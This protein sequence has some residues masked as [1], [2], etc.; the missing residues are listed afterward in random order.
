MSETINLCAPS[1]DP[2]DSYGQIACRLAWHLSQ[3][4]GVH[5]N[6]I[7]PGEILHDSQSAA[8]RAIL[9]QPIRPAVGGLVLGYPTTADLFGGMVAAG[10][11]VA[12]TNWE[13]TIPPEGWVAAL[14]G[15]AAVSVASTF[16]RDVLVAAGVTVPVRV[17]PLG[18]SET[19]HVVERP[20]GRRPF[21]FL[22]L[23]DRNYRKGW[24]QALL[25]F[26]R[27]FDH[28]PAYRLIIKARAKNFRFDV[29]T[30]NVEVLREDLSEHQMQALFARVDAFVFP[31]HG[32]GFGLPPREAAATG[33][34]VIATDWSGTADDLRAW[35]Y[36]LRYSLGPAWHEKGFAGKC[37]DWAEP[38]V[39]H[40]VE[41]M[42][43]VASGS[44]YVAGMAQ[45]AARRIHKLYNWRRFA[46]QVLELWR[47]VTS[48]KVCV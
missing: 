14:N 47:D 23:G 36:P 29:L 27:A 19:Y 20:A 45:H 42:R 6:A 15:M 2:Y 28:D 22:C 4:H 1:F 30:P 46:R 3:E 34:P 24:R 37:G 16:V 17:H 26:V 21:T 18:I 11:R 48:E 5:V 35:G 41:L 8:L 33:L 40:L 31:T 38:D 10:P 39:D 9:S 32:E 44:P 43:Y 12:V 7:G 13:S 25:A